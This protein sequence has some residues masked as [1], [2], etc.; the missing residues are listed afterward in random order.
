MA[1]AA[2]CTDKNIGPVYEGEGGFGFASQVLNVEAA[3]EDGNMIKVP[4]H[5]SG[6]DVNMAEIGFEYDVSG[7]LSGEPEWVAADPSSMF[8]LTT[9]RVIFPDG[10]NTSYAQIRYTDISALSPTGK[11]RMRLTIKGGLTPSG[12]KSVIVTVG[13]RLTFELVGKCDF[14]DSC[15]FLETYETEIYKAKEA[16]IYRVM[17]PYSEGFVAEEYVA[18]GLVQGP[19][20]YIQFLCDDAGNITYEPFKTG[21]LV[22][23]GNE[24]C[25]MTY[26]YYPTDYLTTWGADFSQYAKENRK[27]SDTVFQLCPIY[28]LPDFRHGY[29]D[30]GYFY[31][32][33]TLK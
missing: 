21:M 24:G 12:R 22:P 30:P 13:R 8:S 19:P 33:I 16:D 5:R 26:G 7:N 3:P 27:L 23:V 10:I 15:I 20:D 25:F 14:H 6:G 4:V 9:A 29:L 17:D 2:S 18:D 32:T 11:Y 31:M 28:C 1:V